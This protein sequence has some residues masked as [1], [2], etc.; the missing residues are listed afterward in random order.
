M[1]RE[2]VELIGKYG[3]FVILGHEKPDGDSI[4]SCLALTLAL[5]RLGK[6]AIFVS[7][8]PRP[9]V[10]D[11]LPGREV[12][13]LSS[14]LAPEDFPAE[15][16]IFVDCTD[17][18]RPGKAAAFAGRD[19]WINIDHHI[20]NQGFGLV[21]VVDPGACAAGELVME[22]IKELGVPIDEEIGSCLY[23]AIATDTG[24]FRYSNTSSRSF[25]LAAELVESGVKV[26]E[27]SELIFDAKSVPSLLLA[28]MA[29]GTLR[30]YHGGRVATI[31]VTQEM[32]RKAGASKEDT[33]GLIDYPRSI[34]GVEL[35]MCFKE[36][37]LGNVHVSFRSRRLVDVSRI[38]VGL[39]GGG[40]PRASGATLK[41][42][43]ESALRKVLEIVDGLGIWTDS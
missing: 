20:S 37:D 24:G 29:I 34:A 1:L 43:L 23:V 3:R 32:M 9:A 22:I 6:K 18:L 21:N 19:N 16:T 26:H 15:V 10:Y 8:D 35:A 7:E 31:F 2:V 12:S 5:T 36:D 17:P 30:L 27:I 4:G 11:F 41:M 13:M 39:G 33:D 28:G 42:D 38:A 14:A 25:R 40:H